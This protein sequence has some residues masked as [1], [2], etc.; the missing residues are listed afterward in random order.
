[1][2]FSDYIPVVA[3]LLVI[4]LIIYLQYQLGV[5]KAAAKSAMVLPVGYAV[6]FTVLTVILVPLKMKALFSLALSGWWV[7]G[8][9]LF[10]NLVVVMRKRLLRRQ[11]KKMNCQQK[12]KNGINNN[13]NFSVLILIKNL[14]L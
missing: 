13:V 9:I 4:G 10:I 12:K 1:M 3:L 11:Q 7:T 6:L 5:R 2:P 8:F 14:L